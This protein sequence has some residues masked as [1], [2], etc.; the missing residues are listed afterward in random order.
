MSHIRSHRR[1]AAAIA[2]VVAL[3]WLSKFWVRNNLF[4]EVRHSVVDGWVWLS[5]HENTGIAFSML[6]DL[7]DA[8][9][10]PLLV[11]AALLGIG[12]AGHILLTGNDRWMRLAAGLLVAG[13]LGNLGDRLMGGGVT[14]FIVVRFLP[15]VFNV[16]DVAISA[17]AVLLALRLVRE[18]AEKQPAP[19]PLP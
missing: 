14:D 2:L 4:P 5:H 17:G 9:R 19:A 3:D 7:P 1:L 18:G 10:L 12:V 16:A 8:W 6:A 13:A 15:F 11:A